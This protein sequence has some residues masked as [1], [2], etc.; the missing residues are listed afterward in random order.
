MKYLSK[1][2]LAA[3]LCPAVFA[4]PERSLAIT[5]AKNAPPEV[6][7]A[8][9]RI[10]A[11]AGSHPLLKVLSEGKNVE[12][13]H[14]N[15]AF[16]AGDPERLAYRHLV[17]IGEP[18][19]PLV[20]RIL[21]HEARFENGTVYAF[22][23]GRFSGNLGWI[24]SGPNPFLHSRYIDR[25]PFET[26]LVLI[27]GTTPAGIA[28]AA[29]RFLDSGLVNGLVAAGRVERL[30]TTLLDREPL[31][32]RIAL[33]GFVPQSAAG[34]T[35]IGVTDCSAEPGRGLLEHTG[36]EP[37]RVCAVKYHRPGVWDGAGA[38]HAIE[39][40]LAGLHRAAYGNTLLVAEFATPEQAGT[41]AAKLN[42]EK[43]IEASRKNDGKNPEEPPV[44]CFSRGRYLLMS[45]LPESFNREIAE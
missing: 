28:A 1:L 42:R 21:Q 34:W 32:H 14:F 3:I 19:D 11:A 9:E 40:Y 38:E 31:V 10:A 27:T 30:E 22:G 6:R 8:F 43:R 4:A 35:R 15:E 2:L 26:E 16:A 13:G 29:E 17:V 41:A 25:P 23:F 39:N 7:T 44:N 12:S 24:E 36:S 5:A 33:P 37:L 20:R 18:D 45:T